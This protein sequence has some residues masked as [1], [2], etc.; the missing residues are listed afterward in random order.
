MRT[1][2]LKELHELARKDER[3]VFITGDLGFSVVEAYMEELP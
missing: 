3:I 1:A 2:F